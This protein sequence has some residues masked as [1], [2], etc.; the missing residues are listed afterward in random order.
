MRSVVNKGRPA[1][2]PANVGS[3]TMRGVRRGG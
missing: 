2:V 1:S 3:A